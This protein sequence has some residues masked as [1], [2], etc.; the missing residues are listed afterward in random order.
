MDTKRTG[1]FIGYIVL[2]AVLSILVV[3]VPFIGG[4]WFTKG[5]SPGAQRVDTL[6]LWIT[7]VMILLM[8]FVFG[9]VVYAL[10][11]FSARKGD[12]SDGQPIHGSHRIELLFIIVP[13]IIV[14]LITVFSYVVLQDN[15]VKAADTDMTVHVN[16][17]QFGWKFDYPKFRAADLQDA[18]T[19]KGSP[20]LVLPQ[21]EE[22]NFRI[23]SAKGD[24]LHSFWVPEARV[25]QDAVPGIVRDE[26]WKPDS[27]THRND[28]RKV[29]CAELCGGGHSGMLA[30]YCVVRH[31][32]FVKWTEG[33]GTQTCVDLKKE[34]PK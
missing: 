14:S 11:N 1:R 12:L 34:M 31:D 2:G 16:A 17:F 28:I 27:L 18:K 9:M 22:V 23:S 15:E 10:R 6:T 19:L 32:V 4:S 29:V 24:V 20:N 25:K 33:G 30:D 8:A 21:G 26:Q 3:L 5:I 13:T 7:V